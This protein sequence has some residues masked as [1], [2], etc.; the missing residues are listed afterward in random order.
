M[1]AYD[2]S[3]MKFRRMTPG[4]VIPWDFDGRI[5]ILTVTDLDT[6]GDPASDMGA[7][8][9]AVLTSLGILNTSTLATIGDPNVK[10]GLAGGGT[11]LSVPDSSVIEFS[12]GAEGSGYAYGHP[13]GG[14][15][16]AAKDLSGNPLIAIVVNRGAWSSW[17]PSIHLDDIST[18][19]GLSGPET[20]RVEAQTGEITSPTLDALAAQLGELRATYEARIEKEPEVFSGEFQPAFAR[21]GDLWGR[22]EPA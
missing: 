12:A 5:R 16:V 20:F 10:I 2:T 9:Q 3:G 19:D 17:T 6:A 18:T 15:I 4:G 1:V 21:D 13:D 22:E 7:A 8:L 14:V 11:P